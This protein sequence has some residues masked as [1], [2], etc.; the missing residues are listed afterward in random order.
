MLIPFFQAGVVFDTGSSDAV[1]GMRLSDLT[2]DLNTQLI[3][4]FAEVRVSFGSES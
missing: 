4:V 2:F 3:E 1:L